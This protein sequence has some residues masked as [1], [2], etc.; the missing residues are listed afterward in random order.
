MD[1]KASFDEEWDAKD[2]GCGELVL[3]LRIKLRLSPGKIFKIIATD[4]GA[5]YDI[6]AWCRMTKNELLHTDPVMHSY[7]IKSNY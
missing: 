5:P 3:D 1:T 6:P 4:P 2:M 7:W